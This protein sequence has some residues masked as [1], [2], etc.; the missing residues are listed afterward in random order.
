VLL[1]CLPS[2][3][4]DPTFNAPTIEQHMTK[5]GIRIC[6]RAHIMRICHKN[7]SAVSLG[8]CD[9]N[10]TRKHKA[11]Q[12]M[13]SHFKLFLFSLSQFMFMNE[14]SLFT[15]YLN[16]KHGHY[17]SSGQRLRTNY[18][19]LFHVRTFCCRSEGILIQ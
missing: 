5:S 3:V 11:P 4:F 6:W 19:C 2:R 9:R 17:H 8:R 12:N 14:H 16:A 18:S 7:A 1:L 10:R 15:L 13:R